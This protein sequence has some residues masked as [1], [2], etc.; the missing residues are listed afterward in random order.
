MSRPLSDRRAAKLRRLLAAKAKAGK[1]YSR[2]HALT[3]ELIK[4]TP[5]GVEIAGPDGKRYT[6]QDN[7]AGRVAY[8]T[9]A[10][11]HFEVKEVRPE[12]APR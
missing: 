11:D 2:I 10:I 6:V 3:A 8:K 5:V 9:A 7:F 1:A 4:I 12:K